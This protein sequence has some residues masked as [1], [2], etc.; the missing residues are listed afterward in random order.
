LPC[1]SYPIFC[2]YKR[3]LKKSDFAFSFRIYFVP[4]E[5]VYKKV[6][7]KSKKYVSLAVKKQRKSQ[8]SL[9]SEACNAHVARIGTI[10][11]RAPN[12]N[13]GALSLRTIY[14][15]TDTQTRAQETSFVVHV[16]GCRLLIKSSHVG[17]V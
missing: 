3:R 1:W 11:D 16:A 8:A 5:Q 13:L 2:A 17:T 4:K 7:K 9:T 14:D 6:N 10:D 15:V 12:Q